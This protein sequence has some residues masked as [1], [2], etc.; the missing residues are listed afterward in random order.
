MR[1]KFLKQLQSHPQPLNL[2]DISKAALEFVE[3]LKYS[4]EQ[5]AKEEVETRIQSL[6]RWWFEERQFRITASKF[7]VVIKRVQ[8][9]TSLVSQ[10]LYTA[11]S[12]AV[13]A[14]QWGCEHEPVALQ[15]YSRTLPSAL[16]LSKAGI[17]LDESGYLGVSPDGIV[18]DEAG[19]SIKL[20]EVKC[21]FSAR[22]MTVKEAC[23]EAKSFCC[24]I[25]NN[26]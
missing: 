25:I 16:S 9:H 24:N 7:G 19:H 3:H 10:L 17:F 11:L 2:S 14:L 13:K 1:E 8:Q 4:K 12:P 23:T 21:S 5:R 6:S 15:E 26:S 22:D 20:I 18:V